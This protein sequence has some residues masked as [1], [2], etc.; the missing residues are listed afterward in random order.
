MPGPYGPRS[1]T[2]TVIDLPW[3]L[4]SSIVPQGSVLWATPSVALR[5]FTPHAEVVPAWS[6]QVAWVLLWTVMTVVGVAPRSVAR[7]PLAT[8]RA[9]K[10]PLFGARQRS[11]KLPS[12]PAGPVATVSQLPS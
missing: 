7:A 5:S 1:I 3:K 12:R 2:G 10:R 4:K 11:L 6:Y 9:R 8:A